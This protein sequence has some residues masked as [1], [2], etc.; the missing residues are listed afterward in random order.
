M[1]APPPIATGD[2]HLVPGPLAEESVVAILL[3]GRRL[4]RLMCTPR[5]LDE[6]ALGYLFTRG[7]VRSRSELTGLLVCPDR[8]SVSIDL[9]GDLPEERGPERFVSSAC[10][11]GMPGEGESAAIPRVEPTPVSDAELGSLVTALRTMFSMA[12]LHALTGGVHCAALL[13]KSGDMVMREDVGRHNAVDKVVGR[14]LLD[15]RM[16]EGR[17]LLTSG[18]IAF[19]MVYKAAMAGIG[20]V[21]SRSIPTS[22]AY[23]FAL[24]AGVTL[25][26]RA[27][28]ARPILY[29]IRPSP[30]R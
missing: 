23:E 26:G 20:I 16:Q 27:L 19:D 11:G 13:Y 9:M 3:R 18:R 6:L 2:G 8:G 10:G 17:A 15:D 14:A 12:R 24:N 5:D 22:A 28:A 21:V 29:P 7:L 4:A 25:V 1:Q 30:S